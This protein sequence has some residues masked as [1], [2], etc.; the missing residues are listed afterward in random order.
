MILFLGDSFTWG[1]GLEWIYLMKNEGW[2][3]EMCNSKMPP[4]DCLENLPLKCQDYRLQNHWPR[5]VSEYFDEQYDLGR[6]GNGGSNYDLY[7]ILNNI[8]NFIHPE[9]L[10][11]VI[12]Q[13]TH[14]SRDLKLNGVDYT[15]N[16][17]E[18]DFI[19]AKNT[20]ESF[21]KKYPHIKLFMLSWLPE[22]A[23]LVE[24]YFGESTL[25]KLEYNGTLYN[26]FEPFYQKVSI[27]SEYPK[28]IDHHLS[29]K[30]NKILSDSV[31]KH[32][33]K[34]GTEKRM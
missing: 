2:T 34:Y 26:S 20:F 16:P 18:N 22:M 25:I 4:Q 14:S 6:C 17:F 29:L 5:K 19:E 21:K 7:T 9:N 27:S 28:L 31:I 33:K 15:L 13:F 12:F 1:Q 8:E 24:N 3:P 32:I 10:K 23:E 30:G 11:T